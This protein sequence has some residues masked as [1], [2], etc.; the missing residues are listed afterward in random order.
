MGGDV[1]LVHKQL[2]ALL[3]AKV[4]D[5]P[6]AVLGKGKVVGKDGFVAGR[7]ARPV[8]VGPVAAAQ[9]PVL[10]IAKHKEVDQQLLTH[11]KVQEKR[12]RTGRGGGGL[13]KR[14]LT[15]VGKG[16]GGEEH[17]CLAHEA[18]VVVEVA[19]IAVGLLKSV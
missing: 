4:L 1:L 18:C 5:M 15:T 12:K 7:A 19:R 9:Q 16:G 13:R 10:T 2:V 11:L 6:V 3:A 14:G 8:L 17:T